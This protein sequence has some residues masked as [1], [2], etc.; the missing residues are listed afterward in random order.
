[1]VMPFSSPDMKQRKKQSKPALEITFQRLFF[2]R[3]S[4]FLDDDPVYRLLMAF[5]DAKQLLSVKQFT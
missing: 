2:S 3:S 1:M 4:A 5:A